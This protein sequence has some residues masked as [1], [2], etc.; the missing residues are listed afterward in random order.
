M[1]EVM[2][3]SFFCTVIIVGIAGYLGYHT[4]MSIAIN[5]LSK[6]SELYQRN[7]CTEKAQALIDAANE[8]K[9]VQ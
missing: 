7:G 3:A 6:R 9:S 8:L 5:E 2:A 4:A 1:I